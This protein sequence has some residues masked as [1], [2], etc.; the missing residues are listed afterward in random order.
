MSIISQPPQPPLHDTSPE[1]SL[2]F[3]NLSASEHC[4]LPPSPKSSIALD[5]S[6]GDDEFRANVSSR[7]AALSSQS[8]KSQVSEASGSGILLDSTS[9]LHPSQSQISI[10]NKGENPDENLASESV[11]LIDSEEL[12]SSQNPLKLGSSERT[13]IRVEPNGPED[14]WGTISV[15][16]TRLNDHQTDSQGLR[17][18]SSEAELSILRKSMPHIRDWLSTFTKSHDEGYPTIES[19]TSQS[20]QSSI[21]TRPQ[22]TPPNSTFAG[23]VGVY[24]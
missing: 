4:S 16:S 8:S 22:T 2:V 10:N 6:I 18:F 20:L 12:Q 17:R 24:T 21:Q 19:L 9:P 23:E 13:H 1:R 11:A 5:S 14:S 15:S 7:L 3:P